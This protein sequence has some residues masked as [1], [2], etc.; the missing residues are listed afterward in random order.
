VNVPETF[1]EDLA[2]AVAR[3]GLPPIAYLPSVGSTNDE[4][5]AMANAGAPEFTAVLAD[6]QRSGR[7][8]RGRTWVSPPGAGMYLSVIVKAEGLGDVVPLVTLAAGV[9]VAEAVREVSG[10]PVELKWPNDLVVGET[11]RKLAGILCEAWA[12][13]TPQG[14]MIVGIGVNLQR[15]A[16]PPEVAGR[17]TSLDA[18]CDRPVALVDLVVASLTHL[19]EQVTHLREGHKAVVLQR[20]REIARAGLDHRRVTW[21]DNGTE[22]RGTVRGVSDSGALIVSTVDP[23]AGAYRIEHLIAGDIQW[24]P[25]A[26]G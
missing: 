11:W 14:V 21:Q 17:A 4:A 22:R 26:H 5:L 13:G 2:A 3:A 10:L 23:E 12:L 8:R 18:E 25:F 24:E 16:Y 19:R 20:W 9:A 1:V 7:G 6:E 15:A